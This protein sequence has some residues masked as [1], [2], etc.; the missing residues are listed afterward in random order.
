MEEDKSFAGS[1]GGFSKEPLAAGGIKYRYENFGGI[2]SNES[3]P[4]LAFVDR[5]Y[6]RELGL[7]PSPLWEGADETVGLLSAPTEVHFAVTN[8]CS[9][10]CAHCY[11]DG[12]ERDRGELDTVSFKSALDILAGMGVFHIALGGGEA[13]ERDDLFE[14]AAYAREVGLVPNL[15]V[16]GLRITPEV[17]GKLKI[18]GQVNIS[19]D[20]V[21]G[22]YGVY[23]G[24]NMFEE[25][26]RA[27]DFLN[28]AGVPT[29]IN[30]VVGRE[31]FDG[32]E[33]LFRYSKKKKLNEIEFLRLKPSGRGQSLYMES[34][35]TF[36][37][38]ITLAPKLAKWSRKYK[39]TAKIDCS[40]VP[41]YCYHRPPVEV[42]EG[43]ATYGCEAGNVL[44]GIRSDGSVS[45]CSFLAG[46][47]QTVFHLPAGYSDRE[48]CF[49]QMRSW[50]DRAVEPCLSCEY[51]KICKGGC[52]GVSQYV[53]GNYDA[54]DP[55]CP[56]VVEYHQ[57]GK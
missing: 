31:N 30:C 14:I 9:A 39:I 49:K 51:L 50:V 16:S 15:T 37:Q 18:F 21:G 44:L 24:K 11:M 12:G 35:T 28:Q 5:E 22:L 36:E 46:T 10:G 43:M 47:G 32:L 52:H 57:T 13:L 29:G 19:M 48:G 27:F 6:M 1:R 7:G 54:P 2:I 42:L 45:G 4:F 40:F 26:D 20:G 38:N 41:M 17:A 34:R 56:R 8:R 33:A 55:D 3:P 53:T 25:A 23:R